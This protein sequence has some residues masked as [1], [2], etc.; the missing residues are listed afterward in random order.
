[1]PRVEEERQADRDEAVAVLLAGLGVESLRELAH[2]VEF[3][4][5]PARFGY[6]RVVGM[7]GERVA[8]G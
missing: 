4:K 5:H 8:R 6:S 3:A 1:M 2:A 7:L